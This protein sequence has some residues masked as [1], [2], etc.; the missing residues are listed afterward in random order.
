MNDKRRVVITDEY[1]AVC[2]RA[3]RYAAQLGC[4]VYLMRD[5]KLSTDP[6]NHPGGVDD[7]LETFHPPTVDT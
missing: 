6:V 5:L 1:L 7:I 3:T 4:T 2:R